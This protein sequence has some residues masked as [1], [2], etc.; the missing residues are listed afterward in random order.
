MEWAFV[1][2]VFAH[3]VVIPVFICDSYRY[4]K[5][6]IQTDWIGCGREK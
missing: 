5:F 1:H 3:P 6:K 2:K 4:V